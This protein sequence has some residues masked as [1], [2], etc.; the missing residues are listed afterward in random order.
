[1]ESLLEKLDV[2]TV[3][4]SFTLGLF[5][6]RFSSDM[7]IILKQPDINKM[8]KDSYGQCYKYREYLTEDEKRRRKLI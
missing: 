5:I 4:L 8:Y 2:K 6:I 3:I 1:M 7:N